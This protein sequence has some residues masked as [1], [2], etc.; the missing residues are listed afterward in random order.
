[1]SRSGVF[2]GSRVGAGRSGEPD[3][4]ALEPRYEVTYWCSSGHQSQPHFASTVAAP[5]VWPCDTCGNPAGP[6]AEAPPAAP[7][8]TVVPKTPLEYLLMRRTEAEGDQLLDEALQAL[9][10]RRR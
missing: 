5:D 1:M 8:R 6:T 2:R 4:G 3:R 7:P 10:S 9:R